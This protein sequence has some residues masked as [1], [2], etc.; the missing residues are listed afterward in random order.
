MKVN[1]SRI[2]HQGQQNCVKGY[3]GPNTDTRRMDWLL[4]ERCKPSWRFSHHLFVIS[5]DVLANRG[6]NFEVDH[7]SQ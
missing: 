5:M 6:L 2:I 3:S 4:Q 1:G 7:R